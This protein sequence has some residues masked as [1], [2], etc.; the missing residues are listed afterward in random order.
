M[1]NVDTERFRTILLEERRRA[2]GTLRHL[3]DE[4]SGSIEDEAEDETFDNH[5][6]DAATVTFNREMD[7]SLEGNTGHVL[8][9]IDEALKRIEDGTFGTCSRCG[10]PIA[11]ERLDAMP[12]ATKCID[13][14][15]LEERG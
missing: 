3:H 15:R 11:E 13:C 4:N 10:N 1:A 9:A 12:Y 8:A 5:I 7:Y 14:K 6:G 2:E